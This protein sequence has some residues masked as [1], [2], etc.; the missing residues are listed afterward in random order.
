[1]YFADALRTYGGGDVSCIAS[2]PFSAEQA[3]ELNEA[4]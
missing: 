1:M 4:R 3:A 2:V